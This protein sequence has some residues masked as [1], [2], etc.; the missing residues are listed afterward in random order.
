M[1]CSSAGKDAQRKLLRTAGT[2]DR[3]ETWGGD[4]LFFFKHW[5]EIAEINRW[6]A[7]ESQY[8]VLGF[9][10]MLEVNSEIP[11]GK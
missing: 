7:D 2:S 4:V 9:L 1:S 3:L 11:D 8:R 10:S 6:E 5:Y